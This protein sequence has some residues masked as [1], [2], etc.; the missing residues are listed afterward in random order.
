QAK[1]DRRIAYPVPK[2]EDGRKTLFFGHPLNKQK[3]MRLAGQFI[4]SASTTSPPSPPLCVLPLCVPPLRA[5]AP[6]GSRAACCWIVTSTPR[7]SSIKPFSLDASA[8]SPIFSRRSAI[9][10]SAR[11]LLLELTE[12]PPSASWRST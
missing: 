4:T 3:D 1:P 10:A 12:L 11:A 6:T 2:H 8:R 7:S 5:P 9:S